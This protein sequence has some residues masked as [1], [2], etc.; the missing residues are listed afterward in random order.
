VSVKER[1]TGCEVRTCRAG[2]AE[3]VAAV[4]LHALLPARTAE[5]TDVTVRPFMTP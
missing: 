3:D 4:V 1:G 2:L 5:V